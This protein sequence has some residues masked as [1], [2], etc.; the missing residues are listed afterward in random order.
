MAP[1]PSAVRPLIEQHLQPLEITGADLSF[2]DQVGQQ[3]CD[4]AIEK[5]LSELMHHR[6]SNFASL[7]SAR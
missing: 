6:V 5:P 4:V 7:T 1:L 2:G 3:I